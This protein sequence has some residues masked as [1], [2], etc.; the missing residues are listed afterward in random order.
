MK[1]HA[2]PDNAQLPIENSNLTIAR[3]RARGQP[4][5]V[6]TSDSDGFFTEL[7]SAYKTDAL[8]Q[9]VLSHPESHP[10]FK[11]SNRYLLRANYA[12]ETVLC[13]PKHIHS[14]TK[15]SL[16]GMILHSA[17]HILGHLG[18]QRTADYICRWYW[19]PRI[20][21]DTE[22]F[23]HSCTECQT[24]K[25]FN[26]A[27]YGKLH[28]LPIPERPWESIAM[29]FVGPFPEI[30]ENGVSY[31]YLWVVLCHLTSIV[32]LIPVHTSTTAPE[33]AWIFVRDIVRLHGLPKTI[34]S[35]RDSKFTSKFWT[36]THRILGVKLLL[37]T[38]FHPQT[39]GSS[40]RA[41][42]TITQILRSVV[43]S[44]QR[45]WRMQL[46]IVEYAINSSI[47][48]STK[49]APFELNYGY[50]P[51]ML[52]ELPMHSVAPPEVTEF[53][54]R[55]LQNLKDTHDSIIEARVFQTHH[56]NKHRS[57]DP[58]IQV[59]DLVYVSTKNLSIPAGCARKLVPKFVGPF[60]VEKVN[61]RTSNYT[62]TLSEILKHRRIH[63]TFHIS[64]LRPY[65]ASSDDLFP[66]RSDFGSVALNA[67]PET[68]WLVQEILFHFWNTEGNLWFRVL[69]SLGNETDEPLSNVSKL[70][71]L[72]DYLN[73]QGVRNLQEL[74]GSSKRGRTGRNCRL[75]HEKPDDS[76]GSH[77]NLENPWK[78][79]WMS[80]RN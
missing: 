26:R 19:W 17:H 63:S 8:Y 46:P 15:Q 14:V 5:E 20:F 43:Q 10:S 72:D 32:H 66:N 44:D 1:R 78:N 76:A 73:L 18:A 13:V 37:S 9:K 24:C 80:H 21:T 33:L 64:L 53:A 74:S 3:S 65:L 48:D 36:E 51:F 34:V 28:P 35:D 55:A 38:S 45:D 23:C 30:T 47:S 4:L 16:R 75:S 27:P 79:L 22:I 25:P 12:G 70:H 58:P 54:V 6:V 50:I 57:D 52:K 31:N 67:P 69:W 62:L 42:Q 39:D 2:E 77:Q 71:Q 11:L 41:N 29:D 61:S 7:K 68:E 59:S 56:A 40:E 60:P 49:H